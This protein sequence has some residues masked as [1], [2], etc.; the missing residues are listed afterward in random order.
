MSAEPAPDVAAR[1][2]ARLGQDP[3]WDPATN[4]L[5]W[6]D[7]LSGVVH[8][9]VPGGDDHTLP[10]PQR[11]GAAKPRS[12]GGLVLNLT[13]GIAVFEA[14]GRERTWLVYW[15]RDGVRGAAATVDARG[16]LWAATASDDESG[17]GWLVTIGS[18]GGTHVVLD[19]LAAPTGVTFSPDGALLYLADS[20]TGR[21]DVL[22]VDPATG[23]ASDRRP[24]CALDDAPGEPA[25]LCADAE[26]GVW[27][28][29]RGGG[30]VRRYT[31]DGELDRSVGV[32]V[33]N[34]TGCCFGGVDLTDLYVTSAREGVDNP[35]ESDGALVVIPDAGTG[36]R[37]PFY[38]G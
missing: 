15:A 31:A 9:Y 11:V 18:D 22:D 28:A 27:V 1:A 24:W 2:D 14:N 6:V 33:A 38:A 36:L 32:P 21:V 34:P 19:D 8:R 10:T 5:L 29:V 3:T 23:R 16:R 4:S 35:D 7:V 37:M 26:G 30:Q 25:G 13:E 20:P 17:G 12:R